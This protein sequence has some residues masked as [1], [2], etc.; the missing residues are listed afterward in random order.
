MYIYI[1]T[2]ITYIYIYKKNELRKTPFKLLKIHQ[3]IGVLRIPSNTEDEDFCKS[4]QEL[5]VVTYFCKKIHPRSL[6][7]FVMHVV[8]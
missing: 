2:Y 8:K 4:S 5:S 7:R 6:S 3:R 1:H